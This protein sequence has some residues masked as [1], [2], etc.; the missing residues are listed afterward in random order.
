MAI[1][2]TVIGGGIEALPGRSPHIL[3]PQLS[4]PPC[5]PV[6][7]RAQL[8]YRVLPTTSCPLYAVGGTICTEQLLQ[9]LHGFCVSS[10]YRQL[11]L[12]SVLAGKMQLSS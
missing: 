6:P 3:L 11:I 8:P 7:V 9:F 2:T 4:G 10:H 5:A 1:I 12:G